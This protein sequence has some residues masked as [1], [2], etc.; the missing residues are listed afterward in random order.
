MSP[1]AMKSD[2]FNK[3]KT[4]DYQ[5]DESEIPLLTLYHS[6]KS[7]RDHHYQSH[8]PKIHLQDLYLAPPS[9]ISRFSFHS[10]M[11]LAR[12]R[13]KWLLINIQSATVPACGVLDREIWRHPEI[14]HIVSQSFLFLQLDQ[15]DERAKTYLGIYYD[16]FDLDEGGE[17]IV[18][19]GNIRKFIK[20][21]HIAILDPISRHRWKVWDGP[22]LPDKNLFLADLCEYEMVGEGGWCEWGKGVIRERD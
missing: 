16:V 7:N 17:G 12:E 4:Q 1:L 10:A 18:C 8:P 3:S 2:F 9:P 14:A 19:A 13:K 20:L 11:N 22:G 5:R 21:P 6:K 15:N